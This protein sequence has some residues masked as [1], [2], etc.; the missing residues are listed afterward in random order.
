MTK[1]NP[2]VK[3]SKKFDEGRLAGGAGLKAAKQDNLQL[4]RRATLA[5]LLWEDQ[6][7]IDGESVADE[8]SRLIPLCKPEDVAHLAIEARTMQ[9]LRHIPLYIA[10]EMLKHKDHKAYV[11]LVLPQII[12]RADMITDFAALY[13]KRNGGKMKPMAAAAK[14]GLAKSFENF[15]EYHF[16]KYDRDADVKLRDVMFLVHP[17]PGEGREEL[18]KKIATRTLSTPDTWEVALSTGQDKKDTWTRLITE[19]KIGGL[20]MLRNI[21]NMRGA[22]VDKKVIKQ[23]LTSLKGTMLLPLNFLSAA[24]YNPEFSREIE[25]AMLSSYSSLPKLPGRTLFIVDVS[26]SMEGPSSEHSAF[27]GFDKA[28]AM[29]MLAVNQCEDYEIV[30]TAG[31]DGLRKQASNHLRYP[32][33]GFELIQQLEHTRYDIGYGGIFTRQCLEWCK[34]NIKGDFDRIIV[35][36][37]SQDCDNVN[38]IPKPYGKNN[39][40]CDINA[41]TKGINYQGVWTA[42]ISGWSEHFLT[43]IASMEGISNSFTE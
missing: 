13:A 36:T 32:K 43:F 19:G 30:A 39:Y 10:V 18:Y 4:L 21:R 42:E 26:G 1:L 40:I 12:T 35:F 31:N 23:G 33:K 14:R 20:A 37:D 16:A 41:S 24:K 5:N 8:V 28:A 29:A 38:K 22:G 25:S 34:D 15:K 6:F 7:Y 3:Q 2:T 11:E 17:K 27:T 9:K